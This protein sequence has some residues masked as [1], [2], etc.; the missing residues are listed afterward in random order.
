MLLAAAHFL[1]KDPSFVMD[2]LIVPGHDDKQ[3]MR[4]RSQSDEQ[5]TI[6]IDSFFLDI[7]KSFKN[8]AGRWP[9]ANNTTYATP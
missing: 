3:E 9:F 4:W 7:K 5:L 8:V 1:T 2:L 6:P